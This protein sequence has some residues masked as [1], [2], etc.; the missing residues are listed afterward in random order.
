LF[1]ATLKTNE[2]KTSTPQKK[3]KKTHFNE[4]Q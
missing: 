4:S 3:P 2:T 1:T